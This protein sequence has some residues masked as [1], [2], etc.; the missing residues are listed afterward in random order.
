M[1]RWLMVRFY[2]VRRGIPGGKG[3]WHLMGRKNLVLRVFVYI[4]IFS[5]STCHQFTK[6]FVLCNSKPR[7]MCTLSLHRNIFNTTSF[8]KMDKHSYTLRT[9]HHIWL[10]SRTVSR[11]S[12]R[13]ESLIRLTRARRLSKHVN[14]RAAIKR[15]TRAHAIC[16][17]YVLLLITNLVRRWNKKKK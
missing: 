13:W 9:A 7:E 11:T 6:I 2:A 16:Y 8:K 10:S 3:R 5:T 17:V 15:E 12:A 4:C 14:P 1:L